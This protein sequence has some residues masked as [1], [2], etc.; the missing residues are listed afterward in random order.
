M[1]Q[2]FNAFKFYFENVVDFT[3][4]GVIL[5]ISLSYIMLIK[6]NKIL[7]KDFI[8]L[9]IIFL[10]SYVF[11]FLECGI[12]FAL[13]SVTSV[14][15]FNYNFAL[16]VFIFAI[17]TL[18]EKAVTK[19][20]KIAVLIAAICVVDVLSKFAGILVG[21]FTDISIIISF[22]RMLPSLLFLFTCVLINRIDISKYNTF[23]KETVIV[24]YALAIVLIIASII[25]HQFDNHD[26]YVCALMSLLDIILLLI[27]DTTYVAIYSI[28]QSRHKI[29]NLEVEKTLV[30]AQNLSI[31]IDKNNR[32][33][34]EKLR[35]DLKNQLSYLNLLLKQDKKEEA[36]D[37]INNYVNNQEVLSSFSCS[38][39]VINSIIDLELTKAKVYDI[40]LSLKVAVPPILPFDDNDIVSLLTNM[41]DNAL[42]NYYDESKTIPISVCILKQND[43]I[44]FFVSNPIDV[45]KYDKNNILKSKKNKKGHG[46]GT[47]IIQNIAKKYNGYVDFSIDNNRFLCDALLYLNL[48]D[49]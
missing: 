11:L 43:Y 27:L 48:E 13:A 32:E 33:E 5:L 1:E 6:P 21:I 18:K 28:V 14:F 24:C 30:E 31:A 8:K 9:S 25:E 40:K 36:I 3:T 20:I 44:R 41:V 19:S 39:D 22:G 10:S 12:M 29:T 38:N 7:K 17:C 35:H 15:L 2:F 46:Y 49:K 34:L 45:S 4:F 26:V 47:K 37:Y 23:S 16:M 42:E